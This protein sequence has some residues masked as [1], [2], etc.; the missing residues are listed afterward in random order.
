MNHL[1]ARLNQIL[2]KIT[3]TEFLEGRGLGNEIAFHIFDYPA[4]EELHVREHIRFLLDHIPKKNPSLRVAHMNLF[5]F[6]IEHLKE[7]GLLEK[8]IAMQREKGDRTVLAQLE[9]I[10]HPNKITTAF[11]ARLQ[12]GMHDLALI[13]GVGSVYPLMRAHSL[14]NNLH[15]LMGQTP[16]VMFYPGRYTGQSL[17]LFGR[18]KSDNYY[19]AFKL[20]P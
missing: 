12:P 4:E 10:L 8:V 6:V 13:S 14:L 20:I 1:D 16:L 7:R 9:K 3:S 5:D 2:D 18:L 15:S 17:S 11:A 19:R